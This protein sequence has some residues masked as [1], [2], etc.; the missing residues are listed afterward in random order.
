MSDILW[1]LFISNETYKFH[2]D[3]APNTNSREQMKRN[4]LKDMLNVLY[5]HAFDVSKVI[6]CVYIIWCCHMDPKI[7]CKRNDSLF[8]GT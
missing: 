8:T 5:R 6:G 1:M 7:E 3:H 2:L 4:N